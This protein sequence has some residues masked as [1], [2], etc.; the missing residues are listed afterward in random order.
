MTEDPPRPSRD[1]AKGPGAPRKKG[2]HGALRAVAGAR[3]GKRIVLWFVDEAR[4]GRKGRPCHRW[5]RRGRRPSGRCDRRFER[6][7]IFAAA[8][9]ATGADVALVLPEATAATMSLFSDRV[10]HQPARGRTRGPLGLDGAGGQGARALAAPPD[11]P[12]SRCRPAAR[13][14]TRW[15]GRALRPQGSARASAF[16]RR[17][18]LPIAVPSSTLAARPGTAPSP[19]P[20]GSSSPRDQ[21][22]RKKITPL[23]QTVS[24][25]IQSIEATRA[26]QAFLDQHRG[27]LACRSLL[28]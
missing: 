9:P 16:R 2:L 14:A 22:W 27:N 23:A 11:A 1:G 8:G 3:C 7:C 28:T 26:L 10:R 15:S 17:G 19:G 20:G 6:A 25:T 18:S 21:P 13:R 4:A 5:W 12:W 24:R